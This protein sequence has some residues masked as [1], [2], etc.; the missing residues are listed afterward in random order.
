MFACSGALVF[1]GPGSIP[2]LRASRIAPNS[3]A[4][5]SP[6][7]GVEPGG[8]VAVVGDGAV[9]LCGVLAARRLGAGRIIMLG[10]H[11]GRLASDPV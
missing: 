7:A 8:T 11:E 10:R 3:F 9:G 5:A 6:S 1:T 4:R 2:S